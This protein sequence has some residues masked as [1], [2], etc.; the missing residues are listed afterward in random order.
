MSGPG[1]VQNGPTAV[2]TTGI[3]QPTITGVA[4]NSALIVKYSVDAI[5]AVIAAPTDSAGQTWI[6]VSTF[7]NAGGSGCIAWLPVANAGTHTLSFATRAGAQ[8]G[9]IEEVSGLTGIGGTPVS[10]SATAATITSPSYTPASASEYVSASMFEAGT[11]T[12]DNIHCNTVAFQSIGTLSD[13]TPKPCTMINQNGTTQS[14]VE[15]N[16]AIVTSSAPLT[17]TWAWTGS[18]FCFSMVAGFTLSTGGGKTSIGRPGL[19][20]GTPVSRLRSRY[21]DTVS[22]STIG[23]LSAPGVSASAAVVPLTAT[24]LLAFTGTSASSASFGLSASIAF[25]G[26]SAS[27]A[28]VLVSG[29]IGI[30]GSSA[31]SANFAPSVNIG[32]TGVSASTASFSLLGSGVVAITGASASTALFNATAVGLGSSFAGSSASTAT[33]DLSASAGLL[34]FRGASA[35]AAVLDTSGSIGL[36]S[37]NGVSASI[38]VVDVEPL[39]AGS[40]SFFGASAS[41]ATITLTGPFTP[42]DVVPPPTGA[43]L[44]GVAPKTAI[45]LER[46]FKYPWQATGAPIVPSPYMGSSEALVPL[47]PIIAPQ[48]QAEPVIVPT[49]DEAL[50][51]LLLLGAS[52]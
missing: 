37:F 34:A 22:A 46:G 1:F 38:A 30:V 26:S 36:L 28:I 33:F 4:Q 9:G 24:G 11:T 6:V 7:A 29:G 32:F 47:A 40:I 52:L 31:S 39:S 2:I 14:G 15:A 3:L 50:L 35:S 43:L 18:I 17:V 20:L 45:E 10:N 25:T 44:P 16:A 49:E 12:P 8:Q 51:L 21:S 27:S 42:P 13:S 19:R 23:V 5:N 48:I 41:A